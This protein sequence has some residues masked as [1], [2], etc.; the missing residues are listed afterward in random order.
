MTRLQAPTSNVQRSSKAQTSNFAS[1]VLEHSL[2][3]GAWGLD[4]ANVLKSDP[5]KSGQTRKLVSIRVYPW[6]KARKV[7]QGFGDEKNSPIFSGHFYWKSLGNHTKTAKKN[8]QNHS[9][10]MRFLTCFH[11]GFFGCHR[12]P[13]QVAAPLAMAAQQ[14]HPTVPPFDFDDMLYIKYC[15]RSDLMGLIT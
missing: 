11:L 1:L 7:M 15:V 14:H 9:K 12:P 8:L 4:V 6:L 5:V 13:L 10:N 2:E 3:L